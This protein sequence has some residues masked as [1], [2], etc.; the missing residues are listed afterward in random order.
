M[1]YASVTSTEHRLTVYANNGAAPVSIV[2]LA[3][4]TLLLS[5]DEA[6]A[7]VA[8]LTKVLAAAV[9]EAE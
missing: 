4:L 2:G 1:A 7:L 3:G 6:A 9:G 5:T 8:D